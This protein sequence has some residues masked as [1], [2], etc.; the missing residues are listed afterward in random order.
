MPLSTTRRR[1]APAG[2][3]AHRRRSPAVAAALAVAA[4]VALGGAAAVAQPATAAPQAAVP[5]AAVPA[6]AVPAAAGQ[7]AG[8]GTLDA[9]AAVRAA[10][11]PRTYTFG[12]GANTGVR[13]MNAMKALRAGDTLK[14]LP[15]TY[16]V[17][18]VRPDLRASKGTATRPVTIIAADV[19]RPPLLVGQFVFDDADYWR[20]GS[21]RLQ[22]NIAKRDTL[23]MDSG[24]GWKVVNSEVF[25][26]ANTD[27]FANVVIT[28]IGAR[29]VPAKFQLVGNCIH[30]GGNAPASAR[31]SLHQV[32][33]NAVGDTQGGLIARN[34][35][36]N[37]PYG[38]GVKLGNGGATDA[39][40]PE[41]VQV[42][43]NTFYN[44][45]QSVLLHGRVRGNIVRGNL[46][47]VTT[48]KLTN[49]RDTVGVYL[50]ALTRGRTGTATNSGQQNWFYSSSIPIFN[51]RSASGTFSTG[52]DNYRRPN[53]VLH[54][55]GCSSWAPA[56]QAAK[57]YGK[58]APTNYYYAP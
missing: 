28:K 19:H 53:P 4:S 43:N 17:G 22:G 5:A 49:G 27:A 18:V 23:T 39:P 8:V 56:L 34:I 41:R 12:P 37:S 16:G 30:D 32:Y 45:G 58:Y 54:Q 3:S 11:A 13:L 42:A 21:L 35:I 31:G 57:P 6:A 50:N 25:G 15:G 9:P 44:N 40:G 29:R 46:S 47:V 2:A 1:P 20:F 33:V 52:A 51:Q 36:R 38:A 10:V 48:I 7:A 24:V 26:A 14:I 55:G